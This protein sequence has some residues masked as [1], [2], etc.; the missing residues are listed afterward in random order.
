VDNQRGERGRSEGTRGVQRDKKHVLLETLYSSAFLLQE[1]FPRREGP[2]NPR[3]SVIPL[4]SI[5]AASP[6]SILSNFLCANE[7]G[8]KEKVGLSR[9]KKGVKRREAC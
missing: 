4:A 9:R 7:L 8:R 2:S 5:F 1:P 3:F 6:L